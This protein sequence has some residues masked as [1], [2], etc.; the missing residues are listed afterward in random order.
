MPGSLGVMSASQCAERLR[1]AT[2]VDRN[3]DRVVSAWSG[4]AQVGGSAWCQ[5]PELKPSCYDDVL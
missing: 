4:E 2:P 5:F 3:R 1:P